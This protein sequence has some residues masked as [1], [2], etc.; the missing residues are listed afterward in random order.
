MSDDLE[1]VRVLI[2]RGNGIGLLPEFL[3]GEQR[4]GL[5]RVLSDCAS[6]VASVYFAIRHKNSCPGRFAPSSPWRQ[7]VKPEGSNPGRLSCSKN[8][9]LFRLLDTLSAKRVCFRDAVK[10]KETQ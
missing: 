6:E 5:V 8:L 2:L 7:R 10:I 9:A 1:T 3:G 4:D